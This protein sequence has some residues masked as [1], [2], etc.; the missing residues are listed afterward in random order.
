[1]SVVSP[2]VAVLAGAAVLTRLDALLLNS[3]TR[4]GRAAIMHINAASLVDVP[5]HVP[6]SLDG[7]DAHCMSI[8][9]SGIDWRDV[10]APSRRG[11]RRSDV[12]G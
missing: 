4:N 9:E 7:P 5:V 3:V 8:E 11:A 12:D 1:M 10:S 6:R 2:T